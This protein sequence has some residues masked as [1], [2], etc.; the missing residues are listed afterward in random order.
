M[1]S[2]L[3][4]SRGAPSDATPTTCGRAWRLL[5]LVACL[6]LAPLPATALAHATLVIGTLEV[7]PDP[8]VPGA[9]LAVTVRLEDTL[10]T[11]VEKAFVRVELRAG[12]TDGPAAPES[13]VGSQAG[14]FLAVPPAAASE[15]FTETGVKGTYT[16]SLTAPEAGSYTLSV[17][18][19][20]FLNEEAIA[21]VTLTVGGA[22][23]GAVAFVLPPT[24]T[25]PKSLSTWL[26]WLIGVP[27]LA[28]LVTTV[29]VLR[30]PARSAEADE[31]GASGVGGE[32]GA[33]PG[34]GTDGP[35]RGAP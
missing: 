2:D 17:R 11:P 28:G 7:S 16:G 30:R 15:R 26:L 9:A 5:P 31:G 23:N 34:A 20:T 18:D 22:A 27:L 29:L 14:D 24:P 32:G 25:Q 1:T 12:D 19:T 4:P 10:L 33:G 6:A 3:A 13:A 8:P 21:N 35:E